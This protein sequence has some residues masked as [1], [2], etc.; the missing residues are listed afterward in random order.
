MG[1]VAVGSKALNLSGTGAGGAGA[2]HSVTGTSSWAGAVALDGN[3]SVQVGTGSTLTLSAG[4]G[5]FATN[6]GVTKTGGG[7][8]V[9]GT[10]NYKGTTVINA[11]MVQYGAD[12]AIHSLSA[13]TVNATNNG[14]AVLNVDGF[15]GGWASLTLGGTGAGSSSQNDV[16]I[17]AGTL[18]LGGNVTYL[19]T[20]NPKGSVISAIGGGTLSLGTGTATRTFAVN[21]STNAGAAEDLS[22]EAKVSGAVGVALT[23]TGTGTMVLSGAND[24]AGLT[25]VSAGVLRISNDTGLG[26]TGTTA[27]GTV[28]GN[29]ASLE[30][31][32]PIA[33]GVETLSLTGTGGGGTGALRSRSGVNSWAGAI[34]L[35]GATTIQ[36]DAGTLSLTTVSSSGAA[37]TFG[38]D[39][40]ITVNGVINLVAGTVT[41]VGTGAR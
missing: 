9:L 20:N 24:Y 29:G 40:N 4:I 11:G 3:T 36:A 14:L 19:S 25:T 28:V 37:L 34:T 2:L 21:D 5:Q 41:K 12:D 38:G 10:S 8:L 23:K 6:F 39:G 26:I 13:V 1:S 7:T 32:G 17:G 30:L 18:T 33:V 27:N 35:T 15:T 31:E 22:V 16:T